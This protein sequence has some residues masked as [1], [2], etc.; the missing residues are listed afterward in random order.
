MFSPP[1]PFSQIKSGSFVL[2]KAWLINGVGSEGG[3]LAPHLGQEK[4]AFFEQ[5]LLTSP[6]SLAPAKFHL[7]P[8]YSAP[9]KHWLKTG[10]FPQFGSLHTPKNT[11]F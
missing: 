9:E 2:R 4:W 3:L 10:D 11:A 7:S 1:P 5:Q 8:P 6:Q